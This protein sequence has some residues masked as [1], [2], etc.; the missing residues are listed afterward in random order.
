[1]SKKGNLKRCVKRFEYFFLSFS[2]F[3][4]FSSFLFRKKIEKYFAHTYQQN[5]SIVRSAYAS[6][7]LCTLVSLQ[8]RTYLS[9]FT[10][11]IR[12]EER[13]REFVDEFLT[14]SVLGTELIALTNKYSCFNERKSDDFFFLPES[15]Y[16]FM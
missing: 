16:F 14:S 3:H 8:S 10:K 4:F 15:T 13:T 11:D 12:V 6:C 7:T 2:G 9:P 5:T 1:M